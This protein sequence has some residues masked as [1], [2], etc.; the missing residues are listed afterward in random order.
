MTSVTDHV[1]RLCTAL[2]KTGIDRRFGALSGRHK[3]VALAVAS[4][5]ILAVPP[6]VTTDPVVHQTLGLILAFAVL[7]GVSRLL[8][9]EDPE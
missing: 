1:R 9:G 3:L 5:T 6:I 8:G 4:V 7:D 2:P